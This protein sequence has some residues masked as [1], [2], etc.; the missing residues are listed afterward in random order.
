[1]FVPLFYRL[2]HT[3]EVGAAVTDLLMEVSSLAYVGSDSSSASKGSTKQVVVV[4]DDATQSSLQ[5]LL[6]NKRMVY[7]ILET[8]GMEYDDVFIYDFFQSSPC[9]KTMYTLQELLPD[10]VNE[11]YA[12]KNM[13][14]K[15]PRGQR[16]ST[17]G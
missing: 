9:S 12:E 6:G 8:K 7:T 15:L 14:C 13:V 2:T 4:R 10:N 16:P 5:E 3:V 1:M 11:A 17:R